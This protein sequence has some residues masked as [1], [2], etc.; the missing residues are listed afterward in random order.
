M[1]FLR[2]GNPLVRVPNF[3]WKKT[4]FTTRICWRTSQFSVAC[5]SFLVHRETQLKCYLIPVSWRASLVL[6]WHKL[7]FESCQ[8]I[9]LVGLGHTR[10]QPMV[11]VCAPKIFLSQNID[12]FASVHLKKWTSF[13]K[14]H[15]NL[16][17]LSFL[18]SQMSLEQRLHFWMCNALWQNNLEMRTE[19]WGW[20]SSLELPRQLAADVMTELES[21][22]SWSGVTCDC[23]ALWEL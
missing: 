5:S 8:I 15:K 3:H 18:P 19:Q 11:V 21:P 7:K 22:E 10:K 14:V 2:H 23:P 17:F 12:S 13:G 20:F 6:S 9:F 16:S 4:E 1:F